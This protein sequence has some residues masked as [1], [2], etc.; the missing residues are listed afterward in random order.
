MLLPFRSDGKKVYQVYQTPLGKIDKCRLSNPLTINLSVISSDNYIFIA[1]RNRT[2][3]W[4][5]T[6]GIQPA[7]SRN[8]NKDDLDENGVYDPFS[9]AYRA[10]KEE[11]TGNLI[12][13]LDVTLFGL[14]RTCKTRFPFLFGDVQVGL[15]K[16]VLESNNLT[17]GTPVGIPF[18]VDGV[19]N[20][21]QACY[22]DLKFA[23]K[24]III[25][26]T[27][28]SILESCRHRFSQKDWGHLLQKLDEL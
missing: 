11:V 1:S 16:V 23:E 8:A 14:A 5:I 10:V 6:D 17:G 4:N 25:A 22:N 26:T 2:N 9:H 12:T 18:T 7:I 3:A 27:I 20:W 13:E 21:L 15:P 28:F 24:G 19:S